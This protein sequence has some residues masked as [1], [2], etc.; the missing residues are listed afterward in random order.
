MGIKILAICGSIRR[1]SSN[2][3]ILRAAQGYFATSV[4]DELDLSELPYFDPEAQFGDSTPEA[5]KNARARAAS[6]KLLL[7]STPEYAHGLPG[8]LKNGLEWIFGEETS[9]KKVAVIVGSA[10]GEFASAQL[11]E[12]LRTMDFNVREESFLLMRGVRA[13]LNASG[14][15]ADPATLEVLSRFCANQRIWA[16][17]ND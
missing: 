17:S 14:A 7:I 15:L 10:Q 1:E 11:L 8:I 3:A 16:T 13:K 5:V 2:G 12:I 9:R 4:W 6:A